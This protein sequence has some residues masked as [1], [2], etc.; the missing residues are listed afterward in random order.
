[1]N[2]KFLPQCE[3][4]A[5]LFSGTVLCRN[6]KVSQILFDAG[7][8]EVGSG[9]STLQSESLA[10]TLTLTFKY[11]NKDHLGSNRVVINE[12]DSMEQVTHYY[13][14][15][16]VYAD[17]GLD[18][19]LQKF[20]YNGKELDLMH[21]LNSYD[22][23]ARQYY[24]AVPTWDRVDPMAEKY[25]NESAYSYCKSNPVRMIDLGRNSWNRTI[26]AGN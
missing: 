15:G 18:P 25:P 5:N 10:D 24:A 22:Y 12:N 3:Y 21:G 17:A 13:P 8:V 2:Q 11:F 7:Y 14:F 19:N 4:G 26:R 1:M 9:Q 16:T 23:G 6:G 20:K